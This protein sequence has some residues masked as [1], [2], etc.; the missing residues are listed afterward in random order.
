LP[1]GAAYEAANVP[2]EAYPDGAMAAEAVQRLQAAAANSDEPFFIAVGFTKPHL[3]FCA[4]NKYWDMHDPAGFE[5]AE[6][7]AP[8]A[9]APSYAPTSWG[10]LRQYRGMPDQGAVPSDLQRE[11]IHGYYAATSYMD[12]QVGKVLAALEETGLAETTIVVF[13]GDHGWHLGDHGMWCKHT[14]YEQAARIPL[15]VAAP[16]AAKASASSDSLVESVDVYPTLCE[17][18]G[19]ELPTAIDGVSFAGE[20]AG[21]VRGARSHAS[22][23][24]PRG[25]RL[26]RAIRTERY[27]LVEWKIPGE[28]AD[29]AELELYDYEADPAESNNLAKEQPQVVAELRAL[30]DQQPE[31]KP[32]FKA[33][34]GKQRRAKARVRT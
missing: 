16:S 25:P 9:A 19:V 24:Y 22:H 33:G 4:P 18:A 21:D 34:A 8:P 32:Q 3:P 7:R 17:L 27:R 12:A 2:D 26:G 11:L 1:K 14:N 20:L 5:L 10:E 31:A 15:I 29:S 28:A 6:L 30:L 23:V 13:W